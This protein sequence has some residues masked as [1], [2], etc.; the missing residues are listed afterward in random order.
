MSTNLEIEQ[1]KDREKEKVGGRP[2]QLNEK[3]GDRGLEGEINNKG[4]IFLLEEQH[5]NFVAVVRKYEMLVATNA[6]WK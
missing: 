3:K 5:D 1:E 4:D 2:A 6:R